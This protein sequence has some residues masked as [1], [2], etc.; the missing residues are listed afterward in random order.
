PPCGLKSQVFGI[1]LRR[2][3]VHPSPLGGRRDGGGGA[4][5]CGLQDVSKLLRN[6]FVLISD[7]CFRSLPCWF[8]N[9][10]HWR[11]G[12]SELDSEVSDGAS[13]SCSSF[14]CWSS[15]SW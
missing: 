11:E 10:N 15:C 8:L 9:T 14:P 5:A 7:R 2:E 4:F 3:K 13:L 12:E 6:D 1:V